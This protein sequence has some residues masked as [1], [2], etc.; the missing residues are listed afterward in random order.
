MGTQHKVVYW[1]YTAVVRSIILYSICVWCTALS[2]KSYLNRLM[3]VQR[4]AELCMSGA[5]KT[6]PSATLDILLNL[7]SLDIMGKKAAINLALRLRAYDMWQSNN[8]GHSNIIPVN[9]I[10]TDFVT[11]SLRFGGKKNFEIK[12]PTRDDWS[13]QHQN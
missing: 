10:N 6:I 13:N 9:H 3:K 4:Q 12:F 1:L 11:S 7:P 8:F 2:K 5:L